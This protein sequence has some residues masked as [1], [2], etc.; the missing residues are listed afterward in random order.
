MYDDTYGR[1]LRIA[2]TYHALTVG[3]SR[4]AYAVQSHARKTHFLTD[5]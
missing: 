5:D 2:P 4:D 1:F 3:L